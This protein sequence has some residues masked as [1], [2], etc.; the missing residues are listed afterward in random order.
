MKP[1]LKWPGGK[2]WFIA[3]HANLLPETFERYIEPF[4]GSGSL[5]F[6]LKPKRA[7]LG[8]I[9]DELIA[10]YEG[11]KYDWIEVSDLIEKHE[12]D[13]DEF[14]YYAVRNAKPRKAT[15]QAA[16]L[17]YLNRTCFNGIYRVNSDGK[18]NVPKG[19]RDSIVF[20]DDDFNEVSRRLQNA[21]LHAGDFEVLVNQAK[22]GDLIYADPPY[23]VRH[24]INGFIKYNEVLFSWA[25]QIRLA[26]ALHRALNRGAT[27]VCTNADHE[28]VRSL[29]LGKGFTLK[30]VSRFSPISADPYNRKTFGELVILGNKGDQNK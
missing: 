20:E 28:S 24:N 13:H 8:D 7:L 3:N 27:I 17:I 9:N 1:F 14:H 25:D 29:Y 6:H 4:L 12:E 11:L 30:K 18:F 2:R 15:A 22:S 10:A 5:F 16:R 19:T 26:D 21:T 23:T